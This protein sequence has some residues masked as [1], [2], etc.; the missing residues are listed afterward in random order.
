MALTELK[1]TKPS[2]CAYKCTVEA[3]P[4][5]CTAKRKKQILT[6]VTSLFFLHSYSCVQCT[7]WSRNIFYLSGSQSMKE[8]WCPCYR[9]FGQAWKRSNSP[10]KD[11]EASF[12]D[13]YSDWKLLFLITGGRVFLNFQSTIV[14]YFSKIQQKINY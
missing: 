2:C 7:A 11:F 4:F 10:L 5:R 14:R 12:W 1:A 8:V 13:V 3:N 6:S 9:I